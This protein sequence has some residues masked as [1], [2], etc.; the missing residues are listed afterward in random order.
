MLVRSGPKLD[1]HGEVSV[2]ARYTLHGG[3]QFELGPPLVIQNKRDDDV[4]T[5]RK[6]SREI[7]RESHSSERQ[8]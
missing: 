7:G 3:R 6:V 1:R 2:G 5:G 4:I 8:V